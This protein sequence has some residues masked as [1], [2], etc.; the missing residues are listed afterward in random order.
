M[1][2]IELVA[3]ILVVL[4]FNGCVEETIPPPVPT[5]TP[6]ETPEPAIV[7]TTPAPTPEKAPENIYP[8]TYAVWID[9]DRGFEM[10]R[11]FNG[12]KYI[13]L[14]PDFDILNLS[15]NRGDRV[16]WIN[17]D[18]NEFP[19]SV[20]SNEGLWT[21]RTAYLRWRFARFEYTFN[22]TGTYTFS[23]QG[24]PRVRP[25]KITVDP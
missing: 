19:L 25:Q 23:I 16:R 3:I 12:T 21:N 1:K 11:A 15:I 13:P 18:T 17:D 2:K 20:I 22:E 5:T 14:S 24:Y 8:V 9:S 10:I 6:V 7:P 4:V